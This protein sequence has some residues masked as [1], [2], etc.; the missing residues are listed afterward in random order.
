MLSIFCRC[1]SHTHLPL[2]LPNEPQI[3]AFSSFNGNVWSSEFTA[4]KQMSLHPWASLFRFGA[5]AIFWSSMHKKCDNALRGELL[6]FFWS[7]SD[8]AALQEGPFR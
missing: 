1:L 5:A 7:F 6:S 4:L 2:N 8:L 3:Q